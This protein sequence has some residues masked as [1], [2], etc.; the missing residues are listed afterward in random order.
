[1]QSERRLDPA[2]VPSL[3]VSRDSSR[4]LLQKS[5]AEISCR[6]LLQIRQLFSASG[7]PQ[8]W[9]RVNAD[10]NLAL[11]TIGF[12]A[13]GLC[14][15]A[16]RIPAAPQAANGK[17]ALLLRAR[18]IVEDGA[19]FICRVCGHAGANVRPFFENRRMGNG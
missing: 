10:T 16:L 8:V 3:L 19:L 6:N 15:P 1:M 11:Q 2:A 12:L 7:T 14:T 13:S 9:R 18:P 4:N 5:L 17:A